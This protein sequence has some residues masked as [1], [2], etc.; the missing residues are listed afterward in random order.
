MASEARSQNESG[1]TL[2]RG[3][4]LD[5]DW[6]RKRFAEKHELAVRETL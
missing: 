4:N 3:C 5:G 6:S 1:D 2:L